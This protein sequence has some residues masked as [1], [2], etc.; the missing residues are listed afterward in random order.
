MTILVTGATGQL[1]REVVPLL[2]SRDAGVAALS[3]RV[4]PAFRTADL[5]TGVG[6]AAALEG[7][8]AVVHLAAGTQQQREARNLVAASRSAGIRHLVFI[9]IAGIDRIPLPYYR[10]KL[11][12]EEEIEGGTVPATVQRTTQF[13]PFAAAPFLAQR[14]L[15]VI[16]APR[17]SIQPI[18]IREVA[19]VLADLALSG[20]VG[21]MPDLGGPEVLTGRQLAEQ[22]S[23]RHGWRRRIVDASL[24]GRTWSAFAAGHH[25]V[26]ANRAD[27]RTF[28]DYLAES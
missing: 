27:G 24:P 21:R 4:H 16:V 15:P 9:S 26:P 2:R 18:D 12:A 5:A 3:R 20:P 22:V 7:V 10:A 28:A 23:A 6:L 25:L 14:R 17:L 11:A 8:D 19:R 13:H 1:G